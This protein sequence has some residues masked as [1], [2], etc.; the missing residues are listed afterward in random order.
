[1]YNLYFENTKKR[2]K[3][4]ASFNSWTVNLV[5][6]KRNKIVLELYISRTES[7]P[8]VRLKI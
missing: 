7:V 3:N 6:A 4:L 2:N 5:R 8:V 1:V